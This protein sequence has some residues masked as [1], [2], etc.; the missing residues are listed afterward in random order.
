MSPIPQL[1]W[2]QISVGSDL[3][4]WSP[5]GSLYGTL[6]HTDSSDDTQRPVSPMARNLCRIVQ[7][8]RLGAAQIDNNNLTHAVSSYQED[9][10]TDHVRDDHSP[11]AVHASSSA[12]SNFSGDGI[13]RWVEVSE[14]PASPG[15]RQVVATDA[16]RRASNARRKK[17]A[18]FVCHICEAALTAKHNLQHHLNAHKGIKPHLCDNCNER[19]GTPHVMKRHR[20]TCIKRSGYSPLVGRMKRDV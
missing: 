15:F 18:L 5:S 20:Q 7:D 3:D 14:G 16:G 11:P 12:G 2:D 9:M 1:D 10:A 17:K 13:A 4:E 6:S 8:L 19:F